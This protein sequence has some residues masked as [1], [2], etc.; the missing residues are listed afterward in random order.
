MTGGFVY[1]TMQLN[2]RCSALPLPW[3]FAGSDR[4]GQRVSKYSVVVIA[5]TNDVD[6]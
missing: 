2:E 6:P 4:G 3:L 5:N 1:R